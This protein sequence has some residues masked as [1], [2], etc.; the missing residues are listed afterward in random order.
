MREDGPVAL[1][2]GIAVFVLGILWAVGLK[3]ISLKFETDPG[4]GFNPER[5]ADSN[6]G[7]IPKNQ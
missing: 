2:A 3:R 5:A 1:G 6:P 4:T 7:D